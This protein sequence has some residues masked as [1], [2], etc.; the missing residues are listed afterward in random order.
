MVGISQ[1]DKGVVES[2]LELYTAATKH[3]VALY[4][5][6]RVI[7]PKLSAERFQPYCK[8]LRSYPE[9]RRLC[10]QDHRR[11][12]SETEK[13]GFEICHAGLFNYTLP[14]RVNGQWMCTLLCG[15]VRLSGA[16]NEMLSLQRHEYVV[17][18][19]GLEPRPLKELF[20]Q[21]G[22]I[23]PSR[24][25][26][27]PLI[28]HLRAVQRQFY[29]LLHLALTLQREQE[30]FDRGQENIAHEIQTRL[31]AL[32]ACSENLWRDM[33]PRRPMT[34]RMLY[35]ADEIVKSVQRLDVLVQNLKLGLGEYDFS[36]CDLGV[37]MDR[38]IALYKSEADRKQ[39]SFEVT[40]AEPARIE[41]SP[42]HIEHVMNNLICNAIKYS[43]RGTPARP[44]FVEVVGERKS[45]FYEITME[46]YGI[47]IL[48]EEKQKVFEKGYRGM[49]AR[50]ERR[51]GAGLGLAI[52]KE[53][54]RSHGGS[55]A[56][57]SS[58]VGGS[59]YKTSLIVRLPFASSR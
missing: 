40:M 43:Y 25:D 45:G 41:A 11:R 53:I 56:V 48:P 9:G 21:T 8:R 57:S 14:I 10:D 34:E 28:D 39:V 58:S 20:L 51:T 54:V 46:N 5:G 29:E 33:H 36:S 24:G 35:D 38:S 47:G 55:M 30:E 22:V 26:G 3:A 52:A 59:A 2:L 44:R 49:L 13:E 42:L 7:V 16:A 17:R 27:L 6:E 31:Q 32:L 15:Q 19:L 4:E 18:E 12:G 50:D 1:I 23:D 37:I